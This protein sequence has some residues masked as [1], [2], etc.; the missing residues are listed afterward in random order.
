MSEWKWIDR[1]EQQPAEGDRV[2]MLF[3][4]RSWGLHIWGDRQ[5]M[6]THWMPIPPPPPRM[7][8]IEVHEW[9]ADALAAHCWSEDAERALDEARSACRDALAKREG[10]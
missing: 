1:K 8:T 10:Q 4:D 9:V 5:P 2:L 3:K 6:P 7:V